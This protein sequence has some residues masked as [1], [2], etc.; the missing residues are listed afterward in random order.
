VYPLLWG[1]PQLDLSQREAELAAAKA[2]FTRT[3][4]EGTSELLAKRWAEVT[5]C[6]LNID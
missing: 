3:V 1:P 5:H 2:E 4:D 6:T